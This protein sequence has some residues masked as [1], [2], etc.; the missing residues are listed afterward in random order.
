MIEIIY[1]HKIENDI[2]TQKKISIGHGLPHHGQMD[3]IS[4]IE[5]EVDMRDGT[6]CWA[7]MKWG[8]WR[9]KIKK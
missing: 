2:L 6:I 7:N 1:G 8:F 4:L 9:K 3:L 5:E